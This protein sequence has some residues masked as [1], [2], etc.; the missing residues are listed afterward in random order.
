V[1]AVYDPSK[2]KNP[3]ECMIEQ[4]EKYAGMSRFNYSSSASA[5]QNGYILYQ[6]VSQ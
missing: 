2:S 4:A 1:K 3:T 5:Q 6:F